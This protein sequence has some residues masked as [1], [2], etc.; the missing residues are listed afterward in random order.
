[1]ATENFRLCSK[2]SKKEEIYSENQFFLY[3]VVASLKAQ[4]RWG[5][6][7]DHYALLS[8]SSAGT[9]DTGNTWAQCVRARY[10]FFK[11]GKRKEE[12]RKSS[13]KCCSAT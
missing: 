12:K 6:V 3:G 8:F 10:M 1:M 4:C 2:R 7:M 5:D 13:F 11:W 9:D